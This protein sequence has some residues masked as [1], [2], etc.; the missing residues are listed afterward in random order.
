MTRRL[1]LAAAETMRER[2]DGGAAATTR[3][4]ASGAWDATPIL[5]SCLVVSR[6]PP[7]RTR[8]G[9]EEEKRMS[10]GPAGSEVEPALTAV[11]PRELR[12]CPITMLDPT[13][14]P[15]PA[16]LRMSSIADQVVA[17]RVR[18][19]RPPAAAPSRTLLIR[20]PHRLRARLPL[21]PL[22]S[23]IVA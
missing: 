21:A 11:M 20:S 12:A 16:Q 2:S 22:R 15:V 4:T 6:Q 7:A 1:V 5:Q 9:K 13:P 10:D 17:R 18:A 8:A 3:A 19:R 23:S 14:E